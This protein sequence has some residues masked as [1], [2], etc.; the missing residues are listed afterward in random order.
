[1]E[2]ILL[3]I[4]HNDLAP[5]FDLATK[6]ML[7]SVTRET[8]VM[9]KIE[10]KTV[11]IDPPSPEGM[12]RLAVNEGVHTIIC[13]GI[14]QEYLDFLEWKGIKVMDDICGPVE[15][16]LESFLGGHL[17]RGNSYY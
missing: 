11:V 1:M 5:R 2:K 17:F 14:E 13:A 3:P 10:E 16:I 8:S 12:C 7:V 9:G 6:V 15:A 4:I